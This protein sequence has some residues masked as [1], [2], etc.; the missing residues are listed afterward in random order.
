MKKL[1]LIFGLIL[2]NQ[3]VFGCDCNFEG[4]SFVDMY[5]S[6]G[7]IFEGEIVDLEIKTINSSRYQ[8]I[9]F[10]VTSDFKNKNKKFVTIYNQLSDCFIGITKIG[11]KWLIWAYLY[12]NRLETS[13]CTNSILIDKVDDFQIEELKKLSK[14]DG[15]VTWF[16]K[17]GTKC[18][19]GLY[20][21]KKP[22][23]KWLYYVNGYLHSN[24][25]YKNG[26]KIGKWNVFFQMLPNY[27]EVDP[28]KI[29][30]IENYKNGI[31]NGEYLNF[32]IDGKLISKANVKNGVFY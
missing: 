30:R 7:Y 15:Y 32:S 27:Y 23:G 25:N 24:G 14:V 1:I 2:F 6:A 13:Q 3:Y 21:N 12:E 26:V 10:K 4:K 5:N 16:N 28:K 18:A 8:V 20:S 17:N 11:E 19:E 29:R 31:L 22:T 9:K